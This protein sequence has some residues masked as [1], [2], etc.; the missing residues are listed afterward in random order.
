MEDF[1]SQRTLTKLSGLVGESAPKTNK[2]APVSH[3]KED[4]NRNERNMVKGGFVDEIYESVAE[5]M[6]YFHC[7]YVDW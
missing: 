4:V 7:R 6:S 5:K 3:L 2:V 1:Q